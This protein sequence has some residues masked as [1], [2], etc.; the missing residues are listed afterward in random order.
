MLV[1]LTVEDVSR[2]TPLL[3]LS[4]DDAQKLNGFAGCNRFFG[5][6][7]LSESKI[8][9]SGMG[10]TKMFCQDKSATEDKYLQALREVESFKSESG[11]LF[12]LAGEKTVLEF[13]K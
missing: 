1:Q 12:L 10:S 7:E 9:F 8:K 5:G 3:S 2:V 13:K 4:L 11:K 6:Y